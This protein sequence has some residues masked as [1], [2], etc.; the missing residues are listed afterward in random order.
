MPVRCESVSSNASVSPRGVSEQ[1]Y[2][3]V[4]L[5]TFTVARTISVFCSLAEVLR[6]GV[7]ARACSTSDSNL[8]TLFF[9]QEPYWLLEEDVEWHARL[10]EWERQMRLPGFSR[11]DATQMLDDMIER[12]ELE[13]DKVRLRSLACV[14]QVS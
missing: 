10:K 8:L 5:L 4:D 6:K 1:L 13:H 9:V 2:S 11:E 3:P 14:R 12:W 7:L